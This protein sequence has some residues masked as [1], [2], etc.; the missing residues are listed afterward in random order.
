MQ[1][2]SSSG[3]FDHQHI[4]QYS[5]FCMRICRLDPFSK[6]IVKVGRNPRATYAVSLMAAHTTRHRSP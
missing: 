4:H 5:T 3:S 6:V 1:V 2:P